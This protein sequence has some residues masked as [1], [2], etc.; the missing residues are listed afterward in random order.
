MKTTSIYTFSGPRLLPKNGNGTIANPYTIIHYFLERMS[1]LME[2]SL[3]LVFI[4]MRTFWVTMYLLIL[5][6]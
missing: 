2:K 3:P 1:Y 4:E 5:S 6:C